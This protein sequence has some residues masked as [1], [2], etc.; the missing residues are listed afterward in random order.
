MCSCLLFYAE[1]ASEFLKY[2]PIATDAS[3]SLIRYQLLG[4]ILAVMPWN[5]PFWQVF[6]F[7]APALMAGNVGIFKHASNVPQWLRHTEVRDV[8]SSQIFVRGISNL[9]NRG[10]L[11]LVRDS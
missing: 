8:G 2:V 7:A 11:G 5:F 10:F 6:C 3:R 1:K 9:P 4:I